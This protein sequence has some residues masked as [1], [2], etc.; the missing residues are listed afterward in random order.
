VIVDA[1]G[2]TIDVSSYKRRNVRAAGTGLRNHTYGEI[3]IPRCSYN[4]LF[5]LDFVVNNCDLESE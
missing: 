4:H 3:A 1:G 5:Q 2:G